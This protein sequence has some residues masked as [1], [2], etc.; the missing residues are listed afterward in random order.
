MPTED[1]GLPSAGAVP[2]FVS[3]TLSKPK[4]SCFLQLPF[5][6]IVLHT[7]KELCHP[8]RFDDA[9]VAIL[10]LL[11]KYFKEKVIIFVTFPCFY[12][13]LAYLCGT[14]L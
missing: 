12:P 5:K 10:L 14:N 1:V 3:A 11:C 6:F 9:K 13:I 2:N 8:F 4:A 7:F